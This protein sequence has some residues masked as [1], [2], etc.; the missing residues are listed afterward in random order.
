MKR[1]SRE[2]RWEEMS[3][4]GDIMARRGYFLKTIPKTLIVS[5]FH[6][7]VFLLSSLFVADISLSLFG[8]E[9]KYQPIVPVECST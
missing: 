9:R 5:D 2:E 7:F 1:S 3:W 4:K 6:F 8:V